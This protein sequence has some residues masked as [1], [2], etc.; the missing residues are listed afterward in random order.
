MGGG[1]GGCY[2][3]LKNQLSSPMAMGDNG[4][5]Q[6]LSRLPICIMAGERKTLETNLKY[7]E[8]IKFIS[9]FCRFH[10]ICDE[11]CQVLF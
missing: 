8:I 5:F 1:G 4:H 6:P 9:Y 7:E 10:C 2:N 11:N 3:L